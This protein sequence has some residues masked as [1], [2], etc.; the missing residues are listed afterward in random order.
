MFDRI[1]EISYGKCY[2]YAAVM[3]FAYRVLRKKAFGHPIPEENYFNHPDKYFCDEIYS[4]VSGE[5]MGMKSPNDLYMYMRGKIG[6][7]KSVPV[8]E[9]VV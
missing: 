3:Y 7:F 4:I 5:D 2:D 1:L 8:S 6:K 9:V